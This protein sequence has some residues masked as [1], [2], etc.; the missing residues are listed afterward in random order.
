MLDPV[1]TEAAWN[2]GAVVHRAA[3]D[4]IV[5]SG[6]DAA[7]FL[8]GQVSQEVEGLAVDASTWSLVLQPQGK[9]DGWFRLTR[10]GAEEFWLDLDAGHGQHVLERLQRFKLRTAIDF[11][12]QT[13]SWL[14]VR[15]PEASPP[16]NSRALPPSPVGVTGFDLLGT[17]AE[18]DQALADLGIDEGDPA[19]FD[20]QRIRSGTPAHGHELTD[21]TIPAEAGIV[22]Q[23]VSFTKGCFVGQ[24]LVARVDSRGNNTPRNLAGVR[25][26]GLQQPAEGAELLVDGAA[27]GQITS[28]GTSPS[29]GAVALAYIKRGTE[30]GAAVQVQLPSGEL[31]SAQLV[32]LPF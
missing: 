22:E 24:E 2:T 10:V 32:A 17:E 31:T 16:S 23:S 14:A 6:Q 30:E 8:Q 18:M 29:L 25:I 11:D 9:V 15:G 21:K 3:R 4:R 20:A 19:V 7:S 26:D 28:V 12:L 13:V 5:A 27:V 1:S